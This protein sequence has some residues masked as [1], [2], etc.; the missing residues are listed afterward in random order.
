MDGAYNKTY[1]GN[2]KCIQNFGLEPYLEVI[3]LRPRRRW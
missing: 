1:G 2:R 3:I